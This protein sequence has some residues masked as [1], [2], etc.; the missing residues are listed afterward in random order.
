MMIRFVKMEI[1]YKDARADDIVI[2]KDGVHWYVIEGFY[3]AWG[4]CSHCPRN[5]R[6]IIFAKEE[7]MQ[8]DNTDGWTGK[9]TIYRPIYK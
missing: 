5:M 9:R 4:H 8:R 7:Y 3:H 2:S 6:R 1:E